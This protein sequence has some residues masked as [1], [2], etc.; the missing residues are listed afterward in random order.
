[1]PASFDDPPVDRPRPPPPQSEIKD[2]NVGTILKIGG[3]GC[4]AAFACSCG[5][6][7][8]IIPMM[9]LPYGF[10]PLSGSLSD[11]TLDIMD[12]KLLMRVQ[13]GE[14]VKLLQNTD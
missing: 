14:V 7:F 5:V 4:V 2:E 3:S 8:M 13:S 11:A 12:G 9:M 6:L 10:N 1:M